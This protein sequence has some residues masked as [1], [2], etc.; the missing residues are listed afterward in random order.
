MVLVQ[1]NNLLSFERQLYRFTF[2]VL[3]PKTPAFLADA[4]NDVSL[5]QIIVRVLVIQFLFT[6][7]I[8]FANNQ[9][10]GDRILYPQTGTTQ[11]LSRI[12]RG[13]V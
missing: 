9:V 2:A 6:M 13:N 3:V 8:Y 7:S 5:H 12:E 4:I 1:W 11:K 10:P